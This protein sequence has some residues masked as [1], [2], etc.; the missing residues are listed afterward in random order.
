MSTTTPPLFFVLVRKPKA[1]KTKRNTSRQKRQGGLLTQPAFVWLACVVL[2]CFVGQE[3]KQP[4]HD[5][6]F[7][8]MSNSKKQTQRMFFGFGCEVPQ[9]QTRARESKRTRDNQKKRLNQKDSPQNYSISFCGCSLNFLAFSSSLPLP[10]ISGSPVTRGG[11]ILYLWIPSPAAAV[12]VVAVEPPFL[13]C[14]V[15]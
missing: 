13:V 11:D 14:G 7:S 1:R 4:P 10:A 5:F 15:C 3:I 9:N 6:S 12:D 8:S 2:F